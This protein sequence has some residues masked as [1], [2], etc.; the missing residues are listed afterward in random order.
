MNVKNQKNAAI[1][2]LFSI[3]ILNLFACQ[4]M[5]DIRPIE[6]RI[7]KVEFTFEDDILGDQ[8]R[9]ITATNEE[10]KVGS[11]GLMFYNATTGD[12]FCNTVATVSGGNIATFAMPQEIIDNTVFSKYTI[13]VFTPGSLSFPDNKSLKEY[14]N[15]HTVHTYER[16]KTVM[17]IQSNVRIVPD[18]SFAGETSL[19][20]NTEAPNTSLSV[21]LKRNVIKIEMLHKA[22]RKLHIEWVKVSNYRSQGY[23]FQD[24]IP[25]GS[26][27]IT[28]E[29]G[30]TAISGVKVPLESPSGVAYTQQVSSGLYCL[31][32]IVPH[33][34][35]GDNVTTC[36]IIAAKYKAEG[37]NADRPTEAELAATATTYYR[38]NIHAPIGA[39]QVLS[40]NK[41]YRVVITGVNGPGETD[42]DGA[43]I[44]TDNKLELETD[45]WEDGDGDNIVTD[46]S[47]NYMRVTPINLLFA[48]IADKI[49]KSTIQMTSGCTW[50]AKVTKGADIFEIIPTI[51]DPKTLTVKTRSVGDPYFSKSGE[52]TIQGKAPNGSISTALVQKINL[53]QYSTSQ[54]VSMLSIDGKQ[55]DFTVDA[56][57]DGVILRYQVITGSQYNNWTVT[58]DNDAINMVLDYTKS[59]G[60]GSYLEIHL[61]PNTTSVGEDLLKGLITVNFV[62]PADRPNLIEPIVI[63]LSQ[64][65]SKH[66]I[67]VTPAYSAENPY[68]R[69]VFDY[70][71]N[72]PN[73]AA[74]TVIYVKILDHKKY[75][76]YRV[77]SSFDRVDVGIVANVNVINPAS[78][79]ITF[80][81]ASTVQNFKIY[82]FYTAPGDPTIDGT[83]TITPLDARNQAGIAYSFN[84]KL[85][86]GA[87]VAE[88]AYYDETNKEDPSPVDGH[89]WLWTD[90]EKTQKL[91]IYDRDAGVEHPSALKPRAY[92]FTNAKPTENIEFKGSY[93]TLDNV[94]NGKLEGTNRKYPYVKKWEFIT[95]F[96]HSD[97][98]ISNIRFSK[99]RPFIMS[100]GLNTSNL[101]YGTFLNVAAI[102]PLDHMVLG[103]TW[104]TVNDVNHVVCIN[105]SSPTIT[106]YNLA[107]SGTLWRPLRLVPN[108]L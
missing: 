41:R 51:D 86:T 14:M 85:T 100:H 26:T 17:H 18:L 97:L 90:A 82:Q 54:E 89:V 53:I 76:K 16:M 108:P 13:L 106:W 20:Y 87:H 64:P 47:G 7:S 65:R 74:S 69:D 98:I 9:T 35:Q 52:I 73:G 99:G 48:P 46:P 92:H 80:T 4:T 38:A 43:I 103:H 23:F 84:M 93:W 91:Y 107:A 95:F 66:D 58:P 102:G 63:T 10:K 8:T 36:L 24:G 34:S 55:S 94:Q 71:Y 81:S 101:P 59:G 2:I 45:E 28:G 33:S 30:G 79:V 104:P 75:P 62:A 12:Y 25:L 29:K 15:A 37:W 44:S 70:N 67:M 42:E 78:S 6:S 3:L 22:T 72:G 56:P 40:R 61:K 11:L 96:D 32:N 49:E 88:P 27:V 1:K 83:I 68:V 77:D 105:Y 31:P 50:T 60:N 57:G 5:D 39:S 21:K 19:L